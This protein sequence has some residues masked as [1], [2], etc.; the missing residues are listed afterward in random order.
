MFDNMKMFFRNHFG[1]QMFKLKAFHWSCVFRFYYHMLFISKIYR[2]ILRLTLLD[3][4]FGWPRWLSC[5]S[6]RNQ[7]CIGMEKA[8]G[9]Q[10]SFSPFLVGV[11]FCKLIFSGPFISLSVDQRSWTRK[12]HKIPCNSHSM[13]VWMWEVLHPQRSTQPLFNPCGYLSALNHLLYICL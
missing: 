12:S 13:N 3:L 10:T 4:L 1:K 6:F 11:T 7:Q 9:R 8:V 2:Y 5:L